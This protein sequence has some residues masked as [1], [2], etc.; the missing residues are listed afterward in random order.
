MLTLALLIMAS[1]NC[2][3]DVLRIEQGVE[4]SRLE[5]FVAENTK[6]ECVPHGLWVEYSSDNK[7]RLKAHFNYGISI[8]EWT[9]Y[10]PGGK[11]EKLVNYNEKGKEHGE[12]SYWYSNGQKWQWGYF[13][14]GRQC[15]E[16][17][18][19]WDTGFLKS[20]AV[21]QDGKLNGLIVNYY[22]NGQKAARGQMN[23]DKK[24]GLWIWWNDAG[25]ETK[26]KVIK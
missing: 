26:R 21:W 24:T 4:G 7:P 1:T 22:P 15:G 8:G 9:F 16:W 3:P 25:K 2:P 5:F 18:Q 23:M 13:C 6:G 19:W 11:I 10:R 12:C 17:I 20:R 14:N